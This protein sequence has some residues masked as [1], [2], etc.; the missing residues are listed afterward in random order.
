MNS[1][2]LRDFKD[3]I[4]CQTLELNIINTILKSFSLSNT[5]VIK[6][7]KEKTNNILKNNKFQI[8]KNKIQNKLLLILNKVSSDNIDKLVKNDKN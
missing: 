4:I 1:I 8:N 7:K 6:K 3:N 5:K 2:K